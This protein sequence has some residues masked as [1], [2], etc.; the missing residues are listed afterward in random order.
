MQIA[1]GK[2]LWASFIENF[3]VSSFKHSSKNVNMVNLEKSVLAPTE[4][5][6]PRNWSVTEPKY[7]H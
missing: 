5:G 7:Y 1:C 6:N 4:I 3:H 2:C